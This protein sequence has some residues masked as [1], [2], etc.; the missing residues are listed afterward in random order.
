[1]AASPAGT[2][3]P[4]SHY[5]IS[6]KGDSDFTTI[7]ATDNTAGTVFKATGI[8]MGTGTAARCTV[9]EPAK[10]DPVVEVAMHELVGGV[11]YQITSKCTDCGAS[12]DFTSYGATANGVGT[13]FIATGPRFP[14]D[15]VNG[16]AV[17]VADATQWQPACRGVLNLDTSVACNAVDN[18]VYTPAVCTAAGN[19]LWGS[20]GGARL[21]EMCVGS[22]PA[23]QCTLNAH[24]AAAG[25]VGSCTVAPAACT[26]KGICVERAALSRCQ[27]NPAYMQFFVE[28][29][30]RNALRTGVKQTDRDTCQGVKRSINGELV[31]VCEYTPSSSVPGD[32]ERCARATDRASCE[33]EPAI[34]DLSTPGSG[35]SGTYTQVGSSSAKIP[36]ACEYVMADELYSVT[37]PSVASAGN[38][39][40]QAA[41]QAVSAPT[42]C[43][44]I[45]E[46]DAALCAGV[47]LTPIRDGSFIVASTYTVLS[48]GST[49][50]WEE[51]ADTPSRLAGFVGEPGQVFTAVATGTFP[52]GDGTVLDSTC[53]T[54]KNVGETNACQLQSVFLSTWLDD[55][56]V[57]LSSSSA[58]QY[59]S[60]VGSC[61]YQAPA[62]VPKDANDAQRRQTMLEWSTDLTRQRLTVTATTA[63]NS[64][65]VSE[66]GWPRAFLEV[67]GQMEA[68]ADA[69]CVPGRCQGANIDLDISGSGGSASSQCSREGGLWEDNNQVA[70]R[71]GTAPCLN[72]TADATLGRDGS[73]ANDF[74][75]LHHN[76]E[77]PPG[78]HLTKRV[79]SDPTADWCTAQRVDSCDMQVYVYDGEKPKVFRPGPLRVCT[80]GGAISKVNYATIRVDGRAFQTWQYRGPD[81]T[82]T[83]ATRNYDV[84]V[85]DNVNGNYPSAPATVGDSDENPYGSVLPAIQRIHTQFWPTTRTGQDRFHQLWNADVGV[86]SPLAGPKCLEAAS[87][88]VVND[89]NA[90]EAATK[91]A[92]MDVKTSDPS[93][94]PSATAC[95]YVDNFAPAAQGPSILLGG[96]LCT[97]LLAPQDAQALCTGTATRSICE[98]NILGKSCVWTP[99]P[100]NS[101]KTQLAFMGA[102]KLLIG[103]HTIRWT[104][105]DSYG[106]IETVQQNIDVRD[107]ACPYLTIPARAP[108]TTRCF[109]TSQTVSGTP[110][111][112][113][114]KCQC[115]AHDLDKQACM[116]RAE[117]TYVEDGDVVDFP[118]QAFNELH[119]ERVDTEPGVCFGLVPGLTRT[120]VDNSG[121]DPEVRLVIETITGQFVA[122]DDQYKFPIGSTRVYAIMEDES[123]RNAHAADNYCVE[124]A[125]ASVAVDAARCAAVTAGSGNKCVTVP[126]A[127]RNDPPGT[128]ACSYAAISN[129]NGHGTPVH[130]QFDSECSPIDFIENGV[131]QANCYGSDDCSG[132]CTTNVVGHLDRV[133]F[134]ASDGTQLG[135]CKYEP[136]RPPSQPIGSAGI[137]DDQNPCRPYFNVVVEDKERPMLTDCPATAVSLSADHPIATDNAGCLSQMRFLDSDGSEI[138]AGHRFQ[139]GETAE[140]TVEV[141]DCTGAVTRCMF[142]VEVPGLWARGQSFEQSLSQCDCDCDG[143][144]AATFGLDSYC[145]P[146]PTQGVTQLQLT[147]ALNPRAAPV[148]G[149]GQEQVA[150]ACSASADTTCELITAN[151]AGF[152]PVAGACVGTGSGGCDY[153]SPAA[154]RIGFSTSWQPSKAVVSQ[155]HPSYNVGAWT[156]GDEVVD[157]DE[158][159]VY[160]YLGIAADAF[161]NIDRL[162]K[163]S[164]RQ[165]SET[166]C[167]GSL[168]KCYDN[169]GIVTEGVVANEVV[170]M[171]VGKGW[172]RA[173]CTLDKPERVFVT[174]KRS[175]GA[176]FFA[177]TDPDGAVTVQL[178]STTIPKAALGSTN[179]LMFDYVAGGT[180]E[181]TTGRTV[182]VDIKHGAG[183]ADLVTYTQK[184]GTG[185]DT[186]QAKG[187]E[188]GANSITDVSTGERNADGVDEWRTAKITLDSEWSVLEISLSF[189]S[190]DGAADFAGFDDVRIGTEGCTN[191]HATNYD[192]NAVADDESCDLTVCCPQSTSQNYDETCTSARAARGVCVE[193]QGSARTA[194]LADDIKNLKESQGQMLK[195]V[196]DMYATLQARSTARAEFIATGACPS[197]TPGSRPNG[198]KWWAASEPCTP[199]LAGETSVAGLA[200]TLEGAPAALSC[201]VGPADFAAYPFATV[202]NCPSSLDST[203]SCTSGCQTGYQ[204]KVIRTV[205][206][207]GVTGSALGIG[208]PQCEVLLGCTLDVSTL[209]FVAVS[210]GDC[211][212]T[213]SAGASCQL[214]CQTNF[215]ATYPVRRAVSCDAAGT[216]I[217][218]AQDPGCDETLIPC[219]VDAALYNFDN[220]DAGDCAETL[221]PGET[222]SPGC[223][224]DYVSTAAASIV[225]DGTT[226]TATG[227]ADPMCKRL[228]TVAGSDGAFVDASLTN[229]P[230]GYKLNPGEFC[231]VECA[232]GFEAATYADAPQVAMR[233]GRQRN[234]HSGT[235][236][237]LC[238][239]SGLAALCRRRGLVI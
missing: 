55:P 209:G 72:T 110:D 49:T 156:G 83:A 181:D 149:T 95:V 117:C 165:G 200:C 3:V 66:P 98:G 167:H 194:K 154:E 182:Q 214:E 224:L 112:T 102:K 140:V 109:E 192:P 138:S 207:D 157:C 122:V 123:E 65:R 195:E 120:A 82:P 124:R 221:D 151:Q 12:D 34:G 39:A 96:G 52:F 225:C 239:C 31:S 176:N 142:T 13:I 130:C 89:K 53:S 171:E 238:A 38:A 234:N 87:Q 23:T 139:V 141:S 58:C 190:E 67:I 147:P 204:A 166:E 178:M 91:A 85:T 144:G 92:C 57:G 136:T 115:A 210:A 203:S 105:A 197:G 45:A 127:N 50:N 114:G 42:R 88:S 100:Y 43:T 161:A 69:G 179:V 132:T 228:C 5:T 103:T 212:S 205:S 188:G 70:L 108:P 231:T 232:V 229:C 186:R 168:G 170:E 104:A 121:E 18:C 7:G 77:S 202:G 164:C 150:E 80:D 30:C 36:Q 152:S 131:T 21:K 25:T 133:R 137:A 145:F 32:R 201:P 22:T 97:K 113:N 10:C 6:S 78:F 61:S 222:C 158:I 75:F 206:C 41:C 143:A 8:G 47:T 16:R 35:V 226:G 19:E 183:Q 218:S 213:L 219:V 126:T 4:G 28:D 106:N 146:S 118:S 14:R 2:F 220:A 187:W 27:Q 68:T 129:A 159:G 211:G 40:D 71:G 172:T 20:H 107:C 63:G 94:D 54:T 17:P 119:R 233:S 180:T 59:Y 51:V 189:T 155:S 160:P 101:I 37:C 9:T 198:G 208:D 46:A 1:M 153:V 227:S 99:D 60:P 86:G 33:S 44:H 26:A 84:T 24:S 11:E 185:V 235:R 81:Q 177:I 111:C 223:G 128:Q 15:Y 174:T 199:C 184:W 236:P 29:D 216:G 191:P 163:D 90:C 62:V 116:Q 74:A 79:Y 193:G 230:V 175:P 196:Q 64:D 169:S 217:L 237:E 125:D 134:L 215:L 48:K 93:D 148:E 73:G 162:K 135:T 76:W 56:H 173:A